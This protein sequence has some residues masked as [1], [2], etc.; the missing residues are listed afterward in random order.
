MLQRNIEELLSLQINAKDNEKDHPVAAKIIQRNFYMDDFA[1]SVKTEE[2]FEYEDVR[3]RSSEVSTCS[4]GYATMKPC[5][6]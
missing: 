3:D 6:I 5:V 2:R 1:K 4:N